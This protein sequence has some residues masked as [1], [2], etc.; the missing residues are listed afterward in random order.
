[1]EFVARG[2]PFVAQPELRLTYKGTPIK[3][4]YRPDFVCYGSIIVEIKALSAIT[5]EHVAQVLNYLKATGLRVGL[6]ANLG[7]HPKATIQRFVR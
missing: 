6:L 2:V 1:M 3:S 4:H 7:C 5:P